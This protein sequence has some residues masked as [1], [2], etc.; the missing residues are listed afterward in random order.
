[1]RCDAMRSVVLGFPS[2]FSLCCGG[3]G[4]LGCRRAAATYGGKHYYASLPGAQGEERKRADGGISITYPENSLFAIG[5]RG[6]LL[7]RLVRMVL[8]GFGWFYMVSVSKNKS[9]QAETSRTCLL[10]LLAKQ[11]FVSK[12]VPNVPGCLLSRQTT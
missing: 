1:M 5:S 10:Y 9:K 3:C 12:G 6:K 11:T 4:P 8:D 2:F 7:L